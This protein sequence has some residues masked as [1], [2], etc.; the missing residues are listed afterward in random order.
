MSR[1]Y[2][3]TSKIPTI[4]WLILAGLLIVLIAAESFALYT[5]FTSK[6]P[7]GNDFFVRWL[8]GRE[9]LLHGTNPFDRSIAEQAQ[10]A[11]FGR[12]ATPQD[13]DQAYFAYP[14]YTLYF[15]WPL[16]LIRYAWAQAIWMTL[17][18][19]MLIGATILAIRLVDWQPPTWLYWF[20]VF[21][22]IF[23]YNGARA[24]LLGQFAILVGL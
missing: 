15:F 7:S 3:Q 1:A 2:H 5:V 6:F 23:F 20:T 17:L 16:S 8:G 13:K 10:T 12:L 24:I 18:Q 14:L 9:Y 19:F 4:Q 22:G 21:W 11:M